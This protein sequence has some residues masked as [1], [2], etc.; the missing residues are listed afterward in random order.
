MFSPKRTH[1]T[2]GAGSP[3]MLTFDADLAPSAIDA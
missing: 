3:N 2:D 1:H